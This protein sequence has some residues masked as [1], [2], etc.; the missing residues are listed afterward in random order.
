MVVEFDLHPD[1]TKR[2]DHMG[3]LGKDQPR[4]AGIEDHFGVLV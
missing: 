3:L 4:T 1:A 2:L